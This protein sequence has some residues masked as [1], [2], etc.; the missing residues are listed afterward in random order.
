MNGVG[1]GLH[2]GGSPRSRRPFQ[3]RRPMTTP[4]NRRLTNQSSSVVRHT[5]R[6]MIPK[7]ALSS[8][9]IIQRGNIQ[10]AVRVRP[11]NDAEAVAAH[12]YRYSN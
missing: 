2:R 12:R 7:I 3:I 10:V 1:N 9:A 4:A 11:T 8:D 5:P 6:R